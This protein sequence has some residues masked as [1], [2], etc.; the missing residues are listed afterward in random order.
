MLRRCALSGAEVALIVEVEAVGYRVES[1]RGTEVFH[2][3]EEFVFALE[4]ALSVVALVFRAVEFGGGDDLDR[5]SLLVG[6]SNRVREMSAGE[7]GGVSDD[8]EHVVPEY[9]VSDPSQVGGVD[10]AGVGHEN[11]A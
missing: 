2:H 1:A 4:A 9:F 8:R 10:A 5:D 7:A 11:A 6:E 3:R